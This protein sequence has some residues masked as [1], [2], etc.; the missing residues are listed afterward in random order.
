MKLPVFALAMIIAAPAT[1]FGQDLREAYDA[2]QVA[3]AS[4]DIAAVRKAAAEAH[5]LAQET[6]KS[7][8]PDTPEGKANWKLQ[9]DYAKE[10]STQSEYAIFSLALE[11]PAATQV[12][13]YAAL[14]QMNPKSVYLDDGYARYFYA[15][16]QTGGSAKVIP[17]A[18]KALANLPDNED[19]LLV[20]ADNALNKQ[21][22]DKALA[23][24]NRVVTV[25]NKHTKP[26]G[27]AAGDWEKKKAAGLG[28]GYWT[29][30]VIYGEKQQYMNADKS[31]RA[32]LPLIQGTNSMLSPALYYLGVANY[33]LGK[34][35]LNK[36]QVLEGAAFS[37]KA[38]AIPGALQQQAY[39]NSLI[40]KTEAGQ[41]R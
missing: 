36:K 1:F 38:A 29:A 33:N 35:T 18:E 22:V 31:L 10:V 2:L 39:K 3:Q 12:E 8:V 14:E 26:E 41:M 7:A 16:N 4:K 34:M 15:L 27:V 5:K 19:L 37:E 24:A 40:M 20:L 9:A 28:R 25:L 17:I 11:A 32:A 13:L 21:Q 30:G 23:Y 6:I